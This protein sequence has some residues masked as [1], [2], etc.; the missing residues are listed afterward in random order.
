MTPTK[1]KQLLVST[2]QGE[3]G[4]LDKA[5]RYVFNYNKANG[6][7]ACELSLTMPI[8]AES[9]ATSTLLPVLGMNKPE[10]FLYDEI[11]RRMAKH[12]HIDDMRLLL[13]LGD[14]QIG[15]LRYRQPKLD[16]AS[17]HQPIA[18]A[19]AALLNAVPSPAAPYSS[20][21]AQIGRSELLK[22]A[23]SQALFE[24][25]VETYFESGISGVQPKVMMADA[26]R[27]TA[28]S[29]NAPKA[30]ALHHDLIVKSGGREYPF[31]TQNEFLCMDAARR[32][33]LSVPK[34]WLSDDGGLFVMERFDLHDGQRLGFEDMA[35]LLGKHADS[36]GNYKYQESYEALTRVIQAFC[37]DG[38]KLA[39]RQ[40]LFE[41]VALS[42]MV[43]NGDAHLKNFG[44]LYDHPT[45]HTSP[46]LAPLYDV[47]TTTVYEYV[48][49]PRAGMVGRSMVDRTLAIK[50]NKSK[51]YPSRAQLLQ[52]GS[53]DCGVRHPEKVIDKLATAMGESLKANRSRIDEPFY[54][55]LRREWDSGRLSVE[56]DR[57]FVRTATDEGI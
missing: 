53:R 41:Y 10:G 31:L 35:V 55:K 42:V 24:F 19:S 32:A 13:M 29:P 30:T 23:P 34:F 44:L 43:R 49:P 16:T 51:A 20:T 11:V 2:P 9:Y 4:L 40:R 46:T 39:S 54:A 21:R 14:N 15:R 17:G 7:R 22:H 5:S 27:L 57:V 50:L 26:D 56:P 12:V 6:N 48:Q 37:H 47:V 8:R 38:E 1:I 36:Q 18:P 45:S 28:A 3:S 25:L 52:F 33:G